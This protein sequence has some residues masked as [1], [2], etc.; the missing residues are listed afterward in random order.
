M[1]MAAM[2]M[3]PRLA[4]MDI[5]DIPRTP[6]LLM[7][8][9]VPRGLAAESLLEPARG[10]VMPIMAVAIMD[11]VDTGTVIAAV[12]TAAVMGTVTD[13]AMAAAVTAAASTA[14][15]AAV[16]MAVVVSTAEAAVMVADTGN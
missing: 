6:A 14:D 15:M 3:V 4:R 7:D 2:L 13:M 11:T 8:T 9:M 10:T 12:I 5:T 16:S 1:P